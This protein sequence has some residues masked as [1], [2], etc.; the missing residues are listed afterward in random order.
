[1]KIIEILIALLVISGSVCHGMDQNDNSVLNDSGIK[2]IVHWEQGHSGI[3]EVLATG[4]S[5]EDVM[6]A[7]QYRR[8]AREAAIHNARIALTQIIGD[9]QVNSTA[10]IKIV[11]HS[12]EIAELAEMSMIGKESQAA[13]G[14]YS[15]VMY[16]N[17]FGPHSLASIAADGLSWKI[18]NF[19]GPSAN[20]RPKLDTG[21]EDV[22]SGVIVDARDLKPVVNLL[23]EI[24]DETGRLIYDCRYVDENIVID[25]GL[26]EYVTGNEQYF[27][28]LKGKSRAGVR[29]LVVKGVRTVDNGCNLVIS[30]ENADKILEQN[31]KW[32]ILKRC[33]VIIVL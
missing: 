6:S 2:Y 14:V 5:P 23:P 31:C 17:M 3:I 18:Q 20:F 10:K 28:A 7:V 33:A 15:V 21:L 27:A 19:P 30:E 1:M 4:S 32:G 11:A 29:P 12:A 24:Y 9:I 22:Y 26:V 25:Q 16:V 8:E 13:N